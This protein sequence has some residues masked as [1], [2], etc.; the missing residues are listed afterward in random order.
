MRRK[1]AKTMTDCLLALERRT[2]CGD[3]NSSPSFGED[4][5]MEVTTILGKLARYR[6][7]VTVPSIFF[8]IVSVAP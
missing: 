7:T 1:S 2:G 6:A 4:T 3:A 8:L 5:E